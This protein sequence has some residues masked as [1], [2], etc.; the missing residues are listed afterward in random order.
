MKLSPPKNILPILIL[1]LIL[2]ILFQRINVCGI[3]IQ[4]CNWAGWT[5]FGDFTPPS[6][7]YIRAK[8]L[9]D[10]LDLLIVPILLAVGAWWLNKS[11]EQ[12]KL[13]VEADR[14][15]Q[16]AL[17]NYF[18]KMT[19]LIIDKLHENKEAK[20]IIRTRT[21]GLMRI[22]DGNRKG[23]ALQFIYE[24]GLIYINPVLN[25]NGVDLNNADLSPA[26]L[27]NVEIR[28][29]FVNNANFK[30]ANLSNAVLC[31]SHLIGADFSDAILV[32][33]NFEQAD[34]SKAIFNNAD[35]K[36]SILDSANFNEADL[37]KAKNLTK[38]MVESMGEKE[39]IKL[40]KELVS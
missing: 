38:E 37:S 26:K 34:L 25:L 40:P 29:A 3:E 18:D 22:L 6:E 13:Q 11:Q 7:K 30:K 17:E 21:L 27:N 15:M 8:T 9:W 16:E 2:A 23:Q 36:N 33:T 35:F 14:Q 39:N 10:W 19:E 5:G 12:T 20:S 28:G 32:N 24:L 4:S 31:G 1:A